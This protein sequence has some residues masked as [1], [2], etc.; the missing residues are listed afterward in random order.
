MKL[1]E[2]GLKGNGIAVE[3]GY[4][5][6]IVQMLS[7]IKILDGIEI[8]KQDKEGLNTNFNRITMDMIL[9]KVKNNSKF[10]GM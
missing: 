3:A 4:R 6:P 9:N 5:Y 10:E 7:N 8:T 1:E 2:L